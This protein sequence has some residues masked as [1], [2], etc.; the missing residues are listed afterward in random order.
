MRFGKV[1]LHFVSDGIFLEDGGGLFG[2]L[3]KPLWE[4]VMAPDERNR[5]PLEGWCLLIETE[6]QRIL[7]DTG[8]GDRISKHERDFFGIEGER[9]LLTDLERLDIGPSDVDIV[10]NTHLHRDHC[11]GNTRYDENAKAVPTFPQATYCIQRQEL[12]DFTFPNERTRSVYLPENVQPLEEAGQVQVLWGDTRLTDEVRTIV[13]PGHTR[14]HQ[15]VVVE[16]GG[17]TAIYLADVA[18]WP[19]HLEHL[20]WVPAYDVEPMVNIETKRALA[21]WA[22]EEHIL[23]LFDH[24]PEIRG[25]YL[26]RTER[27]DWFRLEPL[28]DLD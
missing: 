13:T 6:R 17:R 9:R 2:L 20:A 1:N 8:N 10:I 28:P 7:V 5:L 3:P 21:Q 25:G 14:G 4:K 27:P 15:S 11:G 23:L 12:A 16:S 22:V 24:H 26:H 19:I 18:P